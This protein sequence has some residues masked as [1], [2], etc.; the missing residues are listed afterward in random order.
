MLRKQE[1]LGRGARAEEEGGDPM[2]C[3]AMLLTVSRF[4]VMGR[5][6]PGCRSLRVHRDGI[7]FRAISAQSF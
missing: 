5:K 7:S 3:S 4:I 2:G 1:P 6:F